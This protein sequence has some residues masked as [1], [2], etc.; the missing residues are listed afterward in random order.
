VAPLVKTLDGAEIE[1][2]LE[3]AI[4]AAGVTTSRI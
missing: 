1:R 4:E 2:D 3:H